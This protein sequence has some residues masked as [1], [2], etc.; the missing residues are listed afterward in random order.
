[1]ATRRPSCSRT[2]LS[3]SLRSRSARDTQVSE[4]PRLTLPRPT[5]F[6]GVPAS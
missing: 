4:A 3:C 2:P 1:M 5:P 6:P